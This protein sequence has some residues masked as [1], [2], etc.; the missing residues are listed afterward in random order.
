MKTA[1]ET[2]GPSMDTDPVLAEL[3]EELPDASMV[4]VPGCG[5]FLQEERPDD[6]T[7]HLL[8]FLC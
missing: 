4:V 2:L 6:V 3:V 7:G 8:R 1:R 5:H